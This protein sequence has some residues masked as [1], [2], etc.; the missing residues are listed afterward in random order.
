VAVVAAAQLVAQAV[1]QSVAQAATHQRQAHQQPQTPVAAVAVQAMAQAHAM[2]VT[3][4]AELF[5]SQVQGLIMSA[6]YFAQIDNNNVVLTVHVVTAEFMAQNPDRYQGVWV[7]TFFDDP[8]KK[9]A[10]VGWTYDYD[11]QD[12]TPPYVEPVEP[13]EPIDEP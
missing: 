3:G 4:A 11:T 10:G 8:N 7:E 12:F 9:Y 6:Q 2:V 5:I 13:I 1:H